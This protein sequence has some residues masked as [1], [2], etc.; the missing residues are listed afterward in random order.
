MEERIRPG[1]RPGTC[2]VQL[3]ERK[4]ESPQG[5]N[6]QAH[7]RDANQERPAPTRILQQA[8]ARDSHPDHHAGDHERRQDGH[9]RRDKP[10][11]NGHQ[12]ISRI[13]PYGIVELK[14]HRLTSRYR[15]HRPNPEQAQG[16]DEGADQHAQPRAPHNDNLGEND[17]HETVGANNV[18]GEK[19][20][21]H[22][23][24]GQHPPATA[25]NQARGRAARTTLNS[26]T[27]NLPL[28]RIQ[29]GAQLGGNRIHRDAALAL[30][31]AR[32]HNRHTKA[33]QHRKQ[34]IR[35]TIHEQGSHQVPPLIDIVHG[36]QR[37]LARVRRVRKIAQ[38]E[39]NICQR[40]E[41]E[42]KAARDVGGGETHLTFARER[43]GVHDILP[44]GG[45]GAAKGR[46]RRSSGASPLAYVV[47]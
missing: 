22:Q 13:Q 2:P 12:R 34:R 23:A 33:E 11:A 18:T 17:R 4:G 30:H 43:Q 45:V 9:R 16:G 36:R 44:R 20:S 6:P 3:H 10:G 38:P 31:R 35:A 21:V 39:G 37:R 28:E 1:R 19:H 15:R 7:K 32:G 24:E 41:R 5:T 27:D 40:N 14:H 46:G 47:L 25:A 29:P 26:V 8:P 42:H